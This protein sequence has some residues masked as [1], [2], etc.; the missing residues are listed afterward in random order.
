MSKQ[1]D[2][3]WKEKLEKERL[4]KQWIDEKRQERRSN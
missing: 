2:T 3:L 1:E 4:K